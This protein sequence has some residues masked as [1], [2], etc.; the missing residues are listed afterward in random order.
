[1]AGLALT[2]A[3]TGLASAATKAAAPKPSCNLL[4][5]DKGDA[6]FLVSAAP[7]D[8]NLDIVSADVAS[9]AKTFTAVLRLASF[10]GVDPQSPLG[11][12][13]YVQ[14]EPPKADFPVY[15]NMETTPDGTRYTWGDTETLATGNGSYKK[16]GDATGVVD[17]AKGEIRISV[18][19]A[20]LASFVKIRP[21]AK[22]ANL[23]AS[24]TAVLG[25]SV[26]GGLVATVDDGASAAS[27]VAGSP[28]CV[29]PGA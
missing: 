28:S 17:A 2:V 8:P 11:R 24:A 15:F 6:H 21:G 7:N 4:T 29:K 3:C 12:G 20:D 9:D 26:T 18:P 19:L 27:Y 23:T 14:F 25:T 10:A 5:D 22:I 13:Y 16:Q 1:V